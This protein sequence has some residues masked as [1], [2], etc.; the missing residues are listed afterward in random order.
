MRKIILSHSLRFRQAVLFLFSYFIFSLPASAQQFGANVPSVKWQ[1]YNSDTAR[2][3]F[4]AGLDSQARRVASIVHYL[5]A[6]QPVSLGD[7]LYKINIILQPHTTVSN[8]YVAMAPF[9]SEF[10]LTPYSDGFQ[11]GSL[12]WNDLLAIH[13]YR[14]VQQYNNFRIGLTK[15][16]YYLLGEEGIALGTS[17]TVPDWFFEGDAVFAETVLS[18]QGRGRLPYFINQY[19]NLEAAGK[20]YSWLKLRN[21][22]LKDWVPDHYTLGFMLVNHGYQKYGE[23]FWGKVTRDA[24]A[25]K[26]LFYPFQQAVKKHAGVDYKTFRDEALSFAGN[27]GQPG[28]GLPNS[29]LQHKTA[30]TQERDRPQET[31]A[32]GTTASPTNITNASA[33]Y[34]TNYMFPYRLGGDSILYLKNSYRHVRG[35]YIRDATGEHRLHTKHISV[36]DHY[37]YRNGRIVYASFR[38]DARWGLRDYS[39]LNLFDIHSGVHRRVTKR[40]KYFTPDVSADGSRIVASHTDPSGRSELHLLDAYS[41]ELIQ[42]LRSAEI[43]LYS[44]PKFMDDGRVVCVVRLHEGLTSLAVAD[45]TNGS[46][47]RLTPLSYNVVGNPSTENGKVYFTAS[48]GGAD[49]LYMMDIVSRKIFRLTEGLGGDYYASVSDGK[50]LY[51]HFTA[52]GYHLRKFDTRQLVLTAENEMQLQETVTMLPLALTERYRDILL[53]GVPQREFERKKYD[54]AGKLFNFH[55]WRPYYDDPEYYFSVFS[56]NVLSDFSTEVFY[57]YNQ[58]ERTHGGGIN[59]LYGGWFPFVNGGVEFTADRPI[60]VNNTPAF[61]HTIESFIGLSLPLNFTNTLTYKFLNF[62][63]SYVL[64]QQLFKG[65]LKDSIGNANYSYLNHFFS[66]RRFIQQ[67][68][69]HIYPRLGYSFFLSHRHAISRYESFQFFTDNAVYLP[70]IHRTHNLQITGSY[71]KRD[72]INVIFSNRF[73]MSRGYNDFYL[74]RLGGSVSGFRLPVSAMGRLSGNYHFPLLYPDR[75]LANLVYFLRIRANLFFDYTKVLSR[76]KGYSREFKSV[77]GEIFFDTKWWNQLPVTFGIRYS[78]L[79]DRELIGPTDRNVVEFVVPVSLIPE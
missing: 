77:G 36:D 2:I 68:R 69:Q 11:L 75:G 15:G 58:N 51:S 73:V 18:Q 9:R 71:Q 34:V 67:A 13:E 26:G 59:M 16:L 48:Y 56:D 78:R 17:A 8:G 46:T 53:S 19:R 3:I 7:K 44:Y 52:D 40:T 20:N 14:H 62:G 41:G 49:N 47:T 21:G 31:S 70:G 33:D 25:F 72:T 37:S 23:E 60:L 22:S 66:L 55:S 65:P 1:Q 29:G 12:S 4:P 38:P 50:V 57:R 42:S 32:Q 74:G 24:S 64:T 63:S 76:D 5:A 35:F 39:E 43:A 30:I 6:R 10:Y 28:T 61:I 45:F 27:F 79:L 54:R